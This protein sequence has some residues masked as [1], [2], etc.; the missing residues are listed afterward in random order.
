M[1]EIIKLREVTKTYN[2][3]EVVRNVSMDIKRGQIYGFLGPNGAGKTTIMKM[4]LNLVKPTSGIIEVFGEVLNTSSCSYLKRIGN[5]IE[6]P[7]FYDKLTVMENL[8]LHCDY[9]G[10]YDYK[11]IDEVLK[12]VHLDKIGPKPVTEFSLGMKQRLGIARALL[13]NPE[14]LILDEP[15]NGLDPMGI[16]EMR[17]LFLKI[18]KQYNTTILIS[19]HIITEIE[20]IADMIGVINNGKIIKEVTMKDIQ[21]ENLQYIEISVGDQKKAVTVLDSKFQTSNFKVVSDNSIRIYEE[22]IS[23]KDLCK[24]LIL[25]GVNVYGITSKSD[26]LEDYFMN[27]INGGIEQ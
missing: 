18:K 27:L 5:I 26:N 16:K 2:Q 15:I 21:K 9:M 24:E 25:S 4:I 14:L 19:S 1:E 17:E 11:E 12:L 20:Q 13:T 10:F 7:V 3:N 8:K 22:N 23:Q 6:Y